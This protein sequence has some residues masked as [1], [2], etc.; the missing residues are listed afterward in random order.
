M[1]SI[2]LV[3]NIFVYNFEGVDLLEN[4]R[5]KYLWPSSDAHH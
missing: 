1:K 4:Q 5:R 2:S 3:N